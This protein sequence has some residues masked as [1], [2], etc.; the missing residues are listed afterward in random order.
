MTTIPIII[1]DKTNISVIII[2]I[3]SAIIIIL[4][5]RPNTAGKNPFCLVELGNSRLQTHTMPKNL[6]PEWN[7]VF[8][9]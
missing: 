5:L 3:I 8:T 1:A 4:T 7:K 2:P 6:N 9:L